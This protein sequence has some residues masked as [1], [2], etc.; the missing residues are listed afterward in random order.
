[1]LNTINKYA[2]AVITGNL[3]MIAPLLSNDIKVMPPGSNQPNEGKGKTAVMLSAV[4]SA[5][6]DF[7]FIRSYES[8][9]EWYAVL[10]EGT[11]DGTPVQ[12]IDQVH[13]DGNG[14]V[15]HVDIFLRPASTAASLLEKVSAEIKRHTGS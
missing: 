6:T 13:I 9:Q 15:D 1:M 3:E 11:I 4:A 12:F 7:T 10:L 5:I 14:L 2:T 8:E